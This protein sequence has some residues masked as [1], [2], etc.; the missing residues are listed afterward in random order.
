MSFLNYCPLCVLLI[1]PRNV[2]SIRPQILSRCA[3]KRTHCL[4][5]ATVADTNHSPLNTCKPPL[6]SLHRGADNIG[7]F[8]IRTAASAKRATPLLANKIIQF[9]PRSLFNKKIILS[10]QTEL[11]D[12]LSLRAGNHPFVVWQSRISSVSA[13]QYLF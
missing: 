7:P 4:S 12:F 10:P 5:Q 8:L 13:T 11:D 9:Y 1:L 6:I 2:I 3:N